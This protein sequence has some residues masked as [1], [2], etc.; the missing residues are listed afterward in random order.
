[1][2]AGLQLRRAR[3]VA[4]IV[5]R[6]RQG[7]MMRAV[8]L[9][10]RLESSAGSSYA[11]ARLAKWLSDKGHDSRVLTGGAGVLRSLAEYRRL[12]REPVVLHCHGA[13][14][15]TDLFPLAVGR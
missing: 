2:R 11:V 13:W 9:I 5:D 8:Q 14:R 7:R 15:P 12:A 3:R 10:N 6:N 1:M 4:R